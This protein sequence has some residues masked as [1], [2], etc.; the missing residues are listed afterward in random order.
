M[1]YEESVGDNRKRFGEKLPVIRGRLIVQE[2]E[3]LFLRES[4]GGNRSG[5]SAKPPS[6]AFNRT[7]SG[8][9]SAGGPV[10][11]GI[12]SA[13]AGFASLSPRPPSPGLP[14]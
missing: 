3:G 4:G 2:T 10:G 13:K 5:P 11:E 14:L 12:E 9:K 8:L 6:G 1:P 7:K